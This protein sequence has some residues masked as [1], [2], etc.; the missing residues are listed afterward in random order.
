MSS[1]KLFYNRDELGKSINTDE[2]AAL[3]A[4]YQAAHLSKGFRVKKF[5]VKDGAM[6]PII[7]RFN[8]M[9]ENENDEARLLNRTLFGRM[10]NYPQKKV[11]IFNKQFKDFNFKVLYGDMSFLTESEMKDFGKLDLLDVSLT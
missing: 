5:I 3:G 11:M 6:Y 8:K 9:K 1:L 2:S 7:V 10:N 4:V